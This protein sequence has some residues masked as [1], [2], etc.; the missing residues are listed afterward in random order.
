MKTRPV[1]Q[2]L[3]VPFNDSQS[4]YDRLMVA[5]DIAEKLKDKTQFRF[6]FKDMSESVV[7]N[8]LEEIE[9]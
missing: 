8:W 3:S 2:T 9:L 5:A 1:R 4:N 6:E 7:F